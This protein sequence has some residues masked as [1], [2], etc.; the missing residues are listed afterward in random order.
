M[1]EHPVLGAVEC[2]RETTPELPVEHVHGLA[3][4]QAA[5]GFEQLDGLE[6]TQTGHLEVE[7]PEA[8]RIPIGGA[9]LHEEW[10]NI[11]EELSDWANERHRLHQR[12]TAL[13]QGTTCLGWN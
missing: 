12:R 1:T 3:R 6:S 10:K 13:L 5:A 8:E 9:T 2:A 7:H 4:P 11:S